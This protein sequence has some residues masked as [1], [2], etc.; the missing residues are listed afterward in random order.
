MT[1]TVAQRK[2]TKTSLELLYNVGRELAAASDLK[3]VLERVLFLSLKYVQ[4]AGGSI[5]VLDKGGKPVES[6]VIYRGKVLDQTTEQL[7]ETLDEGLAGWVVRNHQAALVINTSQDKRWIKKV[8]EDRKNGG[9]KTTVSAPLTGRDQ[10]VGVMTLTHPTPGYFTEEH[11]ELVQAISDQAGAVVLNA[12]LYEQSQR[13]A[14]IMT[15]LAESA[16]AI[17]SSLQLDEVLNNI[18]E[19]ISRALEVEAVSLGLINAE[20]EVVFRAAAGQSGHDILGMRVKMGQGIAGWVAQE[21]EGLIVPD[22]ASDGRFYSKVDD[23][24]GYRTKSIACAP[25][26]SQGQVIGVLEALN[27]KA[28]FTDEALL[29]LSQI[30]SLAGT[31]IE[32]AQLFEQLDVAH[33]RYRE[34]F[35]D[36]VDPIMITNW[37]GQIVEANR[38]AILFTGFD[39]ATLQT[40]NIHHFHQVDWKTVGKNFVALKENDPLM[41]ESTLYTEK[42]GEIAIEVYV[43]RLVVDDKERMQWILR[44]I[45][46][47]KNLDKLRDD[48]ASMIYHDLRSPL[49]NVVSGLDVLATILPEDSDPTVKSVLDIAMRSTERV[50]RLASSLLDTSRLEAGQQIGNPQP[51]LPAELAQDAV[52]AV[53]PFAKTKQQQIK[54]A[55]PKSLPKMRADVDM[56][57]RVLI[58]LLENAI[59]YTDEEGV[60][61]VGA[62]KQGNWMHM[63][64]EDSGR[65]IPEEDIDKVFQKFHRVRAG[66]TGSTKGLGLGLAFCKLAVEGHGGKI[67]VESKFGEGSKFIFTLPLA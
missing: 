14:R 55:V 35:E 27:P 54:A 3:A 1:E 43:R 25:I 38:Q 39:E 29:L 62:K 19:Q 5:I 64:V 59:K 33:Q 36:S 20:N 41:Y 11:L 50:Q 23:R 22:V 63:W 44:D 52:E 8:Y 28:P 2:G 4:G 31:A 9:P 7:Q 6:A 45:T 34:L 48:L 60:I 40:M 32:H 42:S 49:A 57:K 67:W 56:I 10:L 46:E 51:V 58:N 26:W 21:G 66:R 24:T 13:Q 53:L 61:Y 16:R 12:H 47:R 37:E 17:S 65:G 18:L 15:A 30:G